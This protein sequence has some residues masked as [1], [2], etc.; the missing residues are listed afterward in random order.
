MQGS[1]TYAANKIS[2]YS[3]Y[4]TALCLSVCPSPLCFVSKWLKILSDFFL[5]LVA[6]SLSNLK[7]PLQGIR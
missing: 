6:P 3:F 2:D 7:K 1:V 5:G 4:R